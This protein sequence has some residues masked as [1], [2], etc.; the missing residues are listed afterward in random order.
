MDDYVKNII[1]I[2]NHILEYGFRQKENSFNLEKSKLKEVTHYWD[3]I[4]KYM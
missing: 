3:L 4:T 2:V 1:Y